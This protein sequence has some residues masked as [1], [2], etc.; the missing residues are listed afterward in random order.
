VG[1]VK[2]SV[3]ISTAP[4]PI[5][6]DGPQRGRV[7]D[8]RAVSELPL[9]TRNFTQL[10]ALSPG[11]AVA[12]PDNS[13]LGRNTQNISVNGARTTQNNLQINGVDANRLGVNAASTL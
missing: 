11:A 3:T 8:S 12:L 5:Q 9:A 2:E 4:S 10:L 7:V 6:N 1:D 13:A